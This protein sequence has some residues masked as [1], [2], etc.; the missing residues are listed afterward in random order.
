MKEE[1]NLFTAST[2]LFKIFIC[3]FEHFNPVTNSLIVI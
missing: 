1:E 3:I 2:L